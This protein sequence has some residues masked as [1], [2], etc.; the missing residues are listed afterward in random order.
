MQIKEA[1]AFF[2][3]S[4]YLVHIALPG[5]MKR[6]RESHTHTHTHSVYYYSHCTRSEHGLCMQLVF[7][8]FCCLCSQT[9]IDCSFF[10]FFF[11][12]L[13]STELSSSQHISSHL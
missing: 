2:F 9:A 4:L 12:F 13:F 3:S 1:R 5:V 6:W 7:V 11:I 10:F 8:N